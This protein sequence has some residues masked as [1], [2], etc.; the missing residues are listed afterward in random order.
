LLLRRDRFRNELEEEMRFHREEVEREIE[1]EGASGKEAG[2]A[3]R[4]RFGNETRVREQS[5]EV[6]GFQFETVA[7]DLRFAVRQLR[8]NPG[9]TAT[10]ITTLALGICAS[11]AIF[12]V[13]DAAL[14]RPLPYREPSRLVSLYEA[15]S[16]GPLFHISWPDYLDW[17]RMNKSF[18]AL[19]VYSSRY[20]ME[21]TPQGV[22]KVDGVD[23]S[24]GFFK[25]LGVVPV[26]GR[27]FRTGEDLASAPRTVI[28]SY[29]AWQKRYG[30]RKD[31]LG[32]TVTLNGE[33]NTIIGVLP[34][35]FHFIPAEPAEFWATVHDTQHNRDNHDFFG[36]ARMKQ[37]VSLEQAAADMTTVTSQ[38][39]RQYPNNNRGRG[40][41]LLSLTEVVRGDVRPV[42]VMLLCGAAL[43][44]LIACVNVVSLLLTRAENRRREIAVRGALGASRARLTRQFVT[45]GLLLVATGSMVGATLAAVALRAAEGVVPADMLARMPYL[46]GLRISGHVLLFTAGIVVLAGIVFGVAPV[47]R[48][49]ESVSNESLNEGGRTAAGTGWKRFG[50]KLVVVELATAVVLLVSAGLLG[51]SFYRLLHVETGMRAEHL[52][53][54]MIS[55][56]QAQYAKGDQ[57]RLLTKNLLKRVER[58]PGVASAG[59]ASDLPVGLG[60]GMTIVQVVGN[61]ELHKDDEVVGRFTSPGYFSTLGARLR[62][63]RYYT[64]E[65]ETT[66]LPVV[67]INQTMAR[68]YFASG[69]AVGQQIKFWGMPP[70][71]IIGVIDDIREGP[72]EMEVRPAFYVPYDAAPDPGFGLVVRTEQDEEVLP[73][74]TT[75]VHELDPGI[76]VYGESTMMGKI[77]DSQSATIHRGSAWLIGG[78]AAT[79][80]LLGVV[81]LYGVIAYSVSQRT[82]E[83][84]VR[85]ALGAGRGTVMKMVMRE[86]AWLTVVGIASGL[87]CSVIA[88][89]M[90]RGLLFGVSAWDG[91]TLIAV[92]VVLGGAA[93]AASA[94]PARRA[95][96][97]DPMEALRAE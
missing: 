8:R 23:V 67:M 90:M 88:A 82:R 17:K 70:A 84:G 50:S 62:E 57:I 30:G 64:E 81:G 37:G 83:I 6:V 35:E 4:R 66:K 18:D 29:G 93:L 61:P 65:D 69:Q 49:P 11:V 63:G 54:A 74:L 79:A 96:S 33:L 14:I 58:L 38:L 21:K 7:Q 76:A 28:L 2:R 5:Q 80:L 68:R 40:S 87:A 34:R 85:M 25:T 91:S 73:A 13:V 52:A 22:Q 43:L 72:L 32:Q 78:F 31:V 60:D 27:D 53:T 10:A 15:I 92:A 20:Y 26:L 59:I 86:A 71:R 47:L 1:A 16:V 77:H 45:E 56:P 39:E 44:L 19:D 48:M 89:M 9:F 3:A 55:L 42:L 12:A 51:K 41:T 46:A 97:V 36:V 24:D 95:A 94:I 75:A